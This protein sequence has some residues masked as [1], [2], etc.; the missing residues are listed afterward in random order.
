MTRSIRTVTLAS[1]LRDRRKRSPRERP[2]SLTDGPSALVRERLDTFAAEFLADVRPGL[3]FEYGR[4]VFAND[5]A[6]NVLD[7]TSASDGFVAALKA[8]VRNGVLERGLLLRTS[9]GTYAPV[10]HPAHSRHGHPTRICFLVR[11]SESTA[12]Y[13]SLSERELD[14]LTLLVKGLTNGQIADE[15][16]ISIETVRKHVSRAFEKTGTNTRAGLVGRALGR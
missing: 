1:A 15:L 14:V 5:A 8:S 9:S 2:L 16:G 11:R 4:L 12:A 3:I 10:L 13:E 6:R 7:S